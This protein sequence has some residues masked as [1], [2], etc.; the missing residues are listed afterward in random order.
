MTWV[1]LR[2]GKAPGGPL[3]QALVAGLRNHFARRFLAHAGRPSPEAVRRAAHIRLLDRNLLDRER[4]AVLAIAR[5]H[6][7]SV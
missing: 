7:S 2:A 4:D 5:A 3:R 6:G 1:L